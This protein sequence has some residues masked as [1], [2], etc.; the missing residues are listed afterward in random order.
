LKWKQ[1]FASVWE[2]R[3]VL[4]QFATEKTWILFTKIVRKQ[5]SSGKKLHSH[6]LFPSLKLA[7][8]KSMELV[9]R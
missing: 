4:F 9:P 8:P 5:D 6:Y 3:L 7:L 1:L 2:T